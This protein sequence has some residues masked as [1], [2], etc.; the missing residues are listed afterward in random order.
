ME[1]DSLR[2]TAVDW[3]V[4]QIRQNG[5]DFTKVDNQLV[6]TVP[7]WMYQGAKAIEEE[8]I[9]CAWLDGYC[10]QSPVTDDRNNGSRYYEDKYMGS[11]E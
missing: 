9:V 3:L 2:Q 4:E 1:K 8:Q 7:R 11:S 10:N 6:L 5:L